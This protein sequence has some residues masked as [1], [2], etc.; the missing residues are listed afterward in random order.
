MTE[1]EGNVLHNDYKVRKLTQA[2]SER[3]REIKTLHSLIEETKRQAEAEIQKKDKIIEKLIRS[4]NQYRGFKKST[5]PREK[6]LVETKA[7]SLG[8]A[9]ESA[10]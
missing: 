9:Q 10:A 1:I 4:N 5:K 2:L 8:D 6:A 3:D 7:E